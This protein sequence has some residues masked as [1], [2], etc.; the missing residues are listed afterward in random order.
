MFDLNIN[1]YNEK[2]LEELFGFENDNYTLDELNEKY[3]KIITNVNQKQEVNYNIREKTINFLTIVK[4]QLENKKSI[5]TDLYEDN[6]HFLITNKINTKQSILDDFEK[7]IINPIKKQITYKYLN[8]DSRFRENYSTTNSSN[9][10][11]TL[12]VKLNECLELSLKTIEPPS[13]FN[14][15]SNLLYNN[16]FTVDIDG[17]KTVIEVNDGNY[18]N[19]ISSLLNN[20]N[21]KLNALDCSMNYVDSNTK[22]DF[23]YTGSANPTNVS[24]NFELNKN[25]YSDTVDLEKKIGYILGFTDASYNTNTAANYKITSNRKSNINTLKYCY[26]VVDDFQNNVNPNLIIDQNKYI[27][28]SSII[29]RISLVNYEKTVDYLVNPSRIYFGP[30]DIQKLKIQLV[31]DY[32]RVMDTA[33]FDFS[34]MLEAKINYNV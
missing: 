13:D 19:N 22:I 14:T 11:I 23:V 1:H 6:N 21:S 28:Q 27:T 9:F 16:Y 18:T 30:T 17:T 31:D 26:L 12:D 34:F 24:L 3:M 29:S 32:G 7:D 4:D 20:I 5:L 15:I 8:I 33:N 25:G 2:E 10:S